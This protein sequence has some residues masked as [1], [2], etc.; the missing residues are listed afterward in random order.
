MT[1]DSRKEKKFFLHVFSITQVVSQNDGRFIH[2]KIASDEIAVGI[3]RY[4]HYRLR[5]RYSS[6]H[7]TTIRDIKQCL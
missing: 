2:E 7:G 1:A 5:I 3:D 6:N 4:M